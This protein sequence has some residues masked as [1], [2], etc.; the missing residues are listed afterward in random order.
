MQWLNNRGQLVCRYRFGELVDDLVLRC[1]AQM[2]DRIYI[3]IVLRPPLSVR[4]NII[5]DP[6]SFQFH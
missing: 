4:T 6:Y 5:I 2:F 1:S 3:G